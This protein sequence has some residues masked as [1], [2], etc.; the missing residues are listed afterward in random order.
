MRKK[1]LC[2][3]LAATLA[4]LMVLTGSG[5]SSVGKVFAAEG[6]KIDV[7]DF[8]GVEETDTALYNNNITA[9]TWNEYDNLGKGASGAA[10]EC[11][12]IVLGSDKTAGLDL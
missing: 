12:N 8:G 9:T 2:R 10:I 5:F 1:G 6:R 4:G 3:L 7:W 11:L